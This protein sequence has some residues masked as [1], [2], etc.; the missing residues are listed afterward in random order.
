MPRLIVIC[1]IVLASVFVFDV[2]SEPKPLAKRLGPTPVVVEL[3]TSQG[4]SSCPPA[5]ELLGRI[6]HDPALRGRVIPLAFHVDYWDHL[7]WRDPFSS[8]DW[9]Q[10]Q[11]NYVRVLGLSSAYTPQAVVNG[12][13]ELVGSEERKLF[14]A[15]EAASKRTSSA[16]C[17]ISNGMIHIVAPREVQVIAFTV[18]EEKTTN[19]A[20]GENGGRTLVNFAVVRRLTRLGRPVS[21]RVE[22]VLPPE[23]SVVL[24]QDTRTLEILAACSV[25][26]R[27]AT[28]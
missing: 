8:A 15:I 10:R 21:G 23:S 28:D 25:N 17:S 26:A 16:S 3:F 20:R 22:M 14:D 12:T 9:S 18:D 27:S 19:V 1:T 13:R 5:D 2:A 6:A 24:L 4:C 7:G 11:L